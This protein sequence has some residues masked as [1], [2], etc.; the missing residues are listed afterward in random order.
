MRNSVFAVALLVLVLGCGGAWAADPAA[1]TY[2]WT[3][4]YAGLNAGVAKNISG[5]TLG[6]GKNISGYTLGDG[7]EFSTGGSFDNPAFTVGGQAGYNYQVGNFVYG[8]E[9]DFNYNSTDDSGTGIL[10]GFTAPPG[11]PVGRY[12][13]PYTVNQQIDYFGTLRGRLGFTPADRLLLYVTGGLAY[14]YVSSST[15]IYLDGPDHF[16]GSSSGMQVGWTIGTGGE[17][18]LTN[19]WSVKLEYLYIDLGSTSYTYAGGIGVPASTLTTKIDTAQNVI[20]VG[21]N[22]KF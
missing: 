8:L 13:F 6:D 1:A 14:G 3:G 16:T 21:L 15:N 10:G 2:N 17:Y 19:N 4:F 7:S 18:A 5:Y 9:T 22:Y 11:G 12:G 20:R